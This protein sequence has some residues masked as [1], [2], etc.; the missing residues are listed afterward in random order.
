V[1]E[2]FSMGKVQYFLHGG[3]RFGILQ[4]MTVEAAG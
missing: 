2:Q 3:R 4:V 1:V